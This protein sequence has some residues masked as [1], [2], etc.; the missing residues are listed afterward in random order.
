VKF[1]SVWAVS[2]K[3]K[4]CRCLRQLAGSATRDVELGL[5]QE[6]MATTTP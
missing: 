3:E 2:Q 6:K 5:Q 1:E 4:L